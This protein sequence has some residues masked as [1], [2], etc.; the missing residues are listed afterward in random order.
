MEGSLA[1]SPIQHDLVT[2]PVLANI[3]VVR[4]LLPREVRSLS[5]CS[6]NDQQIPSCKSHCRPQ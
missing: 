1:V 3:G 2:R 5:V 6:M 4:A